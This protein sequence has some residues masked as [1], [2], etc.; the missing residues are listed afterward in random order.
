MI[1][2]TFDTNGYPTEETLAEITRFDLGDLGDRYNLILE[3]VRLIYEHWWNAGWGFKYHPDTGVLE[4]HTAGWSGNEDLI[5][6][7]KEQKWF[8]WWFWCKSTCGGHYWFELYV[9]DA[10]GK[11]IAPDLSGI[12]DDESICQPDTYRTVKVR[13]TATECIELFRCNEEG[14]CAQV[15]LK[16]KDN[17][18][19][20][21]CR[22]YH[23]RQGETPYR[24]TVFWERV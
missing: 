23:T 8:W 5:S 22:D 16:D 15:G 12:L 14:F 11:Q 13:C 9:F 21:V 20:I 4:L 24:K 10:S 2:M 18:I 1:K 6:A 19:A 3:F 7:I 17:G